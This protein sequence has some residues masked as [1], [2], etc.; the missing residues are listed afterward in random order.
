MYTTEMRIPIKVLIITINAL[1]GNT[2]FSENMA[3]QELSIDIQVSTFA[4]ICVF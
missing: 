1:F 4:I 3:H 2:F